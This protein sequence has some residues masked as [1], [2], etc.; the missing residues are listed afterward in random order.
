MA[1]SSL[2]YVHQRMVEH[3]KH[4]ADSLADE[5]SFFAGM[6]CFLSIFNLAVLYGH[7]P[8]V[9]VGAIQILQIFVVCICAVDYRKMCHHRVWERLWGDL[10]VDS[11]DTSRE[12]D[13]LKE[14]DAHNYRLV[15]G[16]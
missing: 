2:S 14:K 16:C 4:L 3:H 11:A 12:A 15:F 7:A 8:L 10:S 1:P 6:A 5:S 9:V 13:I